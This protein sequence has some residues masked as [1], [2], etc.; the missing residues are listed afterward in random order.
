MR[1]KLFPITRENQGVHWPTIKRL[2]K[3][4]GIPEAQTTS[5]AIEFNMDGAFIKVE[6]MGHDTDGRMLMTAEGDDIAKQFE[7]FRIV[8]Y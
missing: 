4:L 8:K 7:K 5:V 2:L 1:P 6:R 3:K